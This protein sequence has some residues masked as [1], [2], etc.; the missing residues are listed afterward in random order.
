MG[1]GA[2][3]FV[4]E[5]DGSSWTAYTRG[6]DG[7]GGP[8]NW[9]DMVLAPGCSA[10][11]S[12]RQAIGAL[13]FDAGISVNTDY[14]SDASAADILLAKDALINTF[15]YADA[16]NGYNDG[17][18]IGS[19]L[20]AMINPNLDAGNPVLLGVWREQGGHA[21]ICDGYGYS[22]STLYHHLNMGWAG[23]D[24]VWYNLPN[25]DAPTE[26][27]SV[28]SCLYN[29]FV[30]GTGEIISGRVTDPSG[31]PVSGA[32]VT[33]EGPVVFHDATTNPNGIY[34]LAGIRS[35]S[36][37]T[38]SVAKMGYFFSDQTVRTGRSRDL[39]PTSGNR[40]Q[41]D[42]VGATAGDCNGDGDINAADFAVF[43]SSWQTS[44]GDPQWNPA[45]DIGEPAD[46]LIDGR[47]L[48]AF[49]RLW[50]GTGR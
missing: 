31:R 48:D 32:T 29:I 7:H 10:T 25:V 22:G 26:Y 1:V 46:G 17:Q 44:P 27:T 41:I 40:W 21:A 9:S 43:A 15:K 33:A 16:V 49:L 50:P 14:E 35:G 28:I 38:V 6:G 23:T 13:C 24:D 5:V 19:G 2:N 39:S 18:D 36:T 20:I 37:Y 47:D 45:C 12:Q 4:V 34:A 8:Y 3:R 11:A 42:F 30:S